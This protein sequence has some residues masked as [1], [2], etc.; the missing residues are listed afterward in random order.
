[1][2][3]EGGWAYAPRFPFEMG[4]TL[5]CERATA[6]YDSTARPTL[7][8]YPK[9]GGSVDPELPAGDAYAAEL[10][11]FLDCI[12][13]GRDP[14]VTTAAD[15][16]RSLELVAAEVRSIRSGGRWVKFAPR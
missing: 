10:D 9:P 11:Y 3:A 8:V 12:R 6:V 13:E 5:V 4:F 16:L 14:A 1:V 7:R 2:T 15:A